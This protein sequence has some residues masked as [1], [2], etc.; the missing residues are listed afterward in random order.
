[1]FLELM[2]IRSLHCCRLFVCID[3]NKTKISLTTPAL[4]M[5]DCISLQYQVHFHCSVIIINFVITSLYFRQLGPYRISPTHFRPSFFPYSSIPV[6]SHLS[7]PHCYL[8]PSTASSHFI[9]CLFFLA[10]HRIKLLY[11]RRLT[12]LA[13]IVFSGCPSVASFSF[14]RRICHFV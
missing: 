8:K 1:M 13:R 6:P 3:T 12:V 14:I 10:V 2:F 7:S 9:Q 11:L 4:S 5:L